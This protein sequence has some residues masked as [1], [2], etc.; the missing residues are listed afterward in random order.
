MNFNNIK[1]SLNII[2]HDTTL[3]LIPM[4]FE[5]KNIREWTDFI[6]KS[7]IDILDW[8]FNSFGQVNN[9]KLGVCIREDID[10]EEFYEWNFIIE[11]K[12]IREFKP[13]MKMNF[14]QFDAIV[15]EHKRAERIDEILE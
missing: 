5:C 3:N 10:Q 1:V 12:N 13:Y 8:P 14:E 7:T 6:R 4:F 2:S 15:K 11:C 9:T